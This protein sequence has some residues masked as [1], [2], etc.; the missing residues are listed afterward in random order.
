MFSC[1]YPLIIDPGQESDLA[2]IFGDLSQS[3][4]RSE[5]K[6]PSIIPQILVRHF[7]RQ[8]Q[9]PHRQIRILEFEILEF[10]QMRKGKEL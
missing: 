4:K 6:P 10:R 5:I 2:P 9:F 7:C 8:H 3:E 1:H